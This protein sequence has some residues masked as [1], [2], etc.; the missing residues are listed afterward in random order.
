MVYLPNLDK[1]LTNSFRVFPSS[2]LVNEYVHVIRGLTIMENCS[3]VYAN[4]CI[5]E[6]LIQVSVECIIYSK[7]TYNE[8]NKA[9]Y[10]FKV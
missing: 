5:F 6:V 3:A 9:G 1:G 10:S 4:L 2:L 8:I 7:N